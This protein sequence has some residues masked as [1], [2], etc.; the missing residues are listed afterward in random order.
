MLCQVPH[1]VVVQDMKIVHVDSNESEANNNQTLA[2]DI[3]NIE[4]CVVE[5]SYDYDES[6]S[7]GHD[8]NIHHTCFKEK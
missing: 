6:F 3:E 8:S 2:Q 4:D 7:R 5:D 1:T